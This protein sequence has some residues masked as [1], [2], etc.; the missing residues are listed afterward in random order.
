MLVTSAFQK[1]LCYGEL[2]CWVGFYSQTYKLFSKLGNRMGGTGRVTLRENNKHVRIR[3]RK[4]EGG[5][6]GERKGG[7]RGN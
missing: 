6:G 2:K 5:G 1:Y 3:F 7:G 4:K